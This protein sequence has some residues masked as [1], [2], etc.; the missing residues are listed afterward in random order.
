MG[1]KLTVIEPRRPVAYSEA[2]GRAVC[3]AIASTP[4]GIDY[5]CATHE[6][7]PSP[8]SIDNWLV[9]HIEFRKA[10]EVAKLRQA[11]LLFDQCLEIADDSSGDTKTIKRNDGREVEVMD[12]EWVAR[13]DLRVRTRL[14]MAGKLN[15]KKYGPKLDIDANLGVIRHED[16]L[17]Q[18]K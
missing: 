7:F 11:D 2:V 6:G 9:E 18:L 14:Q 16:F 13:S 17:D 4:R 3:E 5:L 1:G 15:P 12:R 10:Y 8:R